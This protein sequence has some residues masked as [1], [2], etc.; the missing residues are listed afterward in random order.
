[1]GYLVGDCLIAAAFMSYMGPFL[2][3]YRNF[4]VFLNADIKIIFKY[5]IYQNFKFTFDL[6]LVR[7]RLSRFYELLLD[8]SY[9]NKL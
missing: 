7:L 2:T 3:N 4:P 1:M 6:S 8:L 9:N 5:S